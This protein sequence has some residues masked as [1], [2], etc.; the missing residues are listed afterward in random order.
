MKL[1]KLATA[2]AICTGLAGFAGASP[3][4]SPKQSMM[5]DTYQEVAFVL[6]QSAALDNANPINRDSLAYREKGRQLNNLIEKL[7]TG[8]PVA[9]AEFNATVR[10]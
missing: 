7:R 3:N 9:T 4:I 1:S 8:E 2:A 5:M 6:D 10:R